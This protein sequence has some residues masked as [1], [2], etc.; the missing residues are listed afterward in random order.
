[1]ACLI[2][3]LGTRGVGTVKYFARQNV[4]YAALP[5]VKY[6]AV[7][8]CE[9]FAMGKYDSGLLS[10]NTILVY[11]RSTANRRGRGVQ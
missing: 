3:L 5:I 11:K 10:Q 4:K 6:P 7:A 9:I 1:M 2:L 8:G